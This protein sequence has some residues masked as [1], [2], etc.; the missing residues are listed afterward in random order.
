[1]ARRHADASDAGAGAS[2]L[3]GALILL[4][5]VG[6]YFYNKREVER[7]R[8]GVAGLQEFL[9][10]IDDNFGTSLAPTPRGRMAEVQAAVSFLNDP[11]FE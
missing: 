1:M 3:S 2:D 8:P 7:G 11:G 4:A 5:V 9:I 10:I 6:L